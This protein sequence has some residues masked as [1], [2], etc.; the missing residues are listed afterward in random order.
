MGNGSRYVN[1]GL[2]YLRQIF[3]GQ[4]DIE[5]HTQTEAGKCNF[6]VEPRAYIRSNNAQTSLVKSGPTITHGQGT[7]AH[8]TGGYDA[9]Y[10]SYAYSLVFA[11]D[12]YKL[13]FKGA[14]LDPAKGKLYRDKILKP[15]ASRD[16]LYSLKDF[17]GREPN[18]DGFLENL[19][20]GSK[21]E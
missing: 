20:R 1:A 4:F 15:G 6:S 17:L 16:E 18:S 21:K 12:M 2:F 3:F 11:A 19:L 14:P 13:V 10:Y 8:I 7:F 9:G 5:V